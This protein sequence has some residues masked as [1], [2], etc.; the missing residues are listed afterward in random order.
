MGRQQPGQQP[1]SQP[2]RTLG[3]QI[4]KILTQFKQSNKQIH[5]KPQQ[6]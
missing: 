5:Y 2:H 6:I 4:V 3:I 1:D